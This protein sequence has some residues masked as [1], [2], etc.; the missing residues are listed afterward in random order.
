MKTYDGYVTL[1]L[2]ALRASVSTRSC[3][4]KQHEMLTCL[5][6]RLLLQMMPTMSP[7]NLS[8]FTLVC[9]CL[10]AQ[11]LC[12]L[13][14][15]LCY[16][17]TSNKNTVGLELHVICFQMSVLLRPCFSYLSYLAGSVPSR[18]VTCFTP[19]SDFHFTSST[20]SFSLSRLHIPPFMKCRIV[21]PYLGRLD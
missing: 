17:R 19:I 2:L 5:F 1:H 10:L 14:L 21:E 12:C 15:R 3:F 7:S 6:A 11:L 13:P 8:C 20:L 4:L 16:R 18:L 9:L